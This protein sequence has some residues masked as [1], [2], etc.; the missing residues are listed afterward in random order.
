MDSWMND[1]D[2]RDEMRMS[3]LY[4]DPNWEDTYRE[5]QAASKKA[6]AA[7][8]KAEA[9]AKNKERKDLQAKAQATGQ[10]I[11]VDQEQ[12]KSV[13]VAPFGSV[14]TPHNTVLSPDGWETVV[15]R[16]TVLDNQRRR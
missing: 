13:V 11:L 16:G 14:M 6:E 7:S 15:P 12:N 9:A 1:Q 2:Y 3:D 4:D 5:E 8:K 10:V